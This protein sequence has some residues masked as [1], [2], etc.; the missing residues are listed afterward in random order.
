MAWQT[1]NQ[2]YANN[3]EALSRA[4]YGRGT[5]GTEHGINSDW[6]GT[7]SGQNPYRFRNEYNQYLSGLPEGEQ[8]LANSGVRGA[9]FVNTPGALGDQA[10]AAQGIPAEG[11]SSFSLSPEVLAKMWR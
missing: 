3:P 4:G 2:Y 9:A 10:R 7:E 8:A 1:Y 6:S 11:G 5:T